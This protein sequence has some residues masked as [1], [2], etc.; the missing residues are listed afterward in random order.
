MGYECRNAELFYRQHK[1][2]RAAPTRWMLTLTQKAMLF[3]V[4]AGK[5]TLSDIFNFDIFSWRSLKFRAE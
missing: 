1:Q 4:I 5:N 2:D 3:R